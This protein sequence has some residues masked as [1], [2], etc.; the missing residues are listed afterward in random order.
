MTASALV[1]IGASWLFGG[2]S[3]DVLTG[4]PLTIVDRSVADWFHSHATPVVTQWMLAF[5]H[6]HG[7]V[8]ISAYAA[9]LAL[10]LA[11]KRD[12]YWLSCLGTTVPGGMLLNVM[13]KYAFQRGR[14]IFDHPLLTLSTYSF[15]SGHVAGSVLFYGV[16]GALLVSRT[17]VWRWRVLIIFSAMALVVMV[18]LTRVYLGVH[19]LSDVLA[20]FAESVAWLS[21]CLMSMHTYWR[22][23]AEHHRKATS[24]AGSIPSRLED[25]GP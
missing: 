2:I 14:P 17:R 16:L 15:P 24:A 20:A 1:L 7:V 22:H 19:Y 11:W 21:L 5:T 6:L 10:Y 9:M 8:A 23:R 13:M 3:E 25:P 12:W 18:A 4:D